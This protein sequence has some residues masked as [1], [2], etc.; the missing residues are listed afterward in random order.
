LQE[1][2]REIGRE[3]YR[4]IIIE[5]RGREGRERRKMEREVEG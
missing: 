5:R 1:R 4:Y 3:R 2:E